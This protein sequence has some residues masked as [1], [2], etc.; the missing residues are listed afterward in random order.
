MT[1]SMI[2]ELE[3]RKVDN[4]FNSKITKILTIN[5]VKATIFITGLWAQQYKKETIYLFNNP[6]VLPVYKA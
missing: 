1:P 5:D 2:K 6:T 4:Y 3:D